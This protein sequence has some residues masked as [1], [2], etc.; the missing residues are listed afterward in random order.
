MGKGIG[1]QKCSYPIAKKK[2]KKSSRRRPTET[3]RCTKRRRRERQGGRL[4]DFLL[5]NFGWCNLLKSFVWACATCSYRDGPGT[6][7]HVFYQVVLCYRLKR[8]RQG[9]ASYKKK[10][11]KIPAIETK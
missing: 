11:N 10:A 4:N 5:E 6:D 2:K 7:P 9:Y 8:N 1:I 3:S